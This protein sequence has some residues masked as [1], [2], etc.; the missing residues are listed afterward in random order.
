MTFFYI[1]LIGGGVG[2]IRG[3]GGDKIIKKCNLI[4]KIF[5]NNKILFFGLEEWVLSLIMS[6]RLSYFLSVIII[7]LVLGGKRSLIFVK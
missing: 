7:I 6:P 4:N 5:P 2:I 1:L 3:G